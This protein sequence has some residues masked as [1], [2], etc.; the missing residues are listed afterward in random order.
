M[1]TLSCKGWFIDYV[2]V[3]ETTASDI[4][5]DHFAKSPEKINLYQNYPNPFNPTTTIQFKLPE[6]SDVS[7]RIYDI[8]GKLVKTLI[9]E[10]KDAGYHSV[11]WDGTGD[12]GASVNSGVYFYKIETDGHSD[13]KRCVMLK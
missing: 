7:L 2:V 5:Q 12:D 4:P 10:E 9:D 11:I 3:Y 1:N 13:V 6:K 8:S